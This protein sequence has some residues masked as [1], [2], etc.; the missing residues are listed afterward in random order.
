MKISCVAKMVTNV[1]FG[2]LGSAAHCWHT[3]DCQT[4]RPPSRTCP[5]PCSGIASPRWLLDLLTGV[6]EQLLVHRVLFTATG[7]QRR[8]EPVQHHV[9]HV[10]ARL[11]PRAR[12][13]NPAI[14]AKTKV[15]GQRTRVLAAGA[16]RRLVRD[17]PLSAEALL[18]GRHGYH[19][20][21]T[22]GARVGRLRA[23]GHNEALNL[24]LR[25]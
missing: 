1:P 15:G 12:I 2:V 20:E 7:L 21:R 25:C 4:A 17:E 13:L 23:G 11:N 5:T 18:H 24:L 14:Q 16:A 6:Q 10:R 8:V 22:A 9:G 19:G 3:R